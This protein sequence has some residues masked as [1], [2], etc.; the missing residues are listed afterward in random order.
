MLCRGRG[1]IAIVVISRAVVLL[2]GLDRREQ[3]AMRRGHRL[4]QL[5]LLLLLRRSILHSEL[6]MFVIRQNQGSLLLLLLRVVLFGPGR[7]RQ[8]MFLRSVV[9]SMYEAGQ[10]C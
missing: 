8:Q 10:G 5:L 6:D 7:L 1:I 2:A 9:G 4:L 3:A